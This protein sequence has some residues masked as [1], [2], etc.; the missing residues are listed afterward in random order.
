[1]KELQDKKSYYER[2]RA[3]LEAQLNLLK[4]KERTLIEELKGHDRQSMEFELSR[5]K[6]RL[7]EIEK[8]KA[9]VQEREREIKELKERE[10]KVEKA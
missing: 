6:E 2:E 3:S 9:L 4:E 10:E 7:E 5:L 8:E 1:M